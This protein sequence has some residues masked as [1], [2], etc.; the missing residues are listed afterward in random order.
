MLLGFVACQNDY[1]G[2]E[3][4]ANGEAAV[5]LN[6]AIPEDITRAAGANSAL[7][8]VSNID[9]SEY[10]IRFIL[11]V[12]DDANNLAKE[13]IVKYEDNASATSFSLR[14]IPGRGYKFVAWADFVKQ[15]QKGDYHYN[16]TAG[17][18]NI[19]VNEATWKAMD[20]SRD[21]YTTVEE[22]ANFSSAAN[23]SLTLKR[24]F[25]KVRV[26]ATDIKEL[27]GDLLPKDIEVEYLTKFYTSYNALTK[28]ASDAAQT[29][30][31]SVDLSVL[32]YASESPKDNGKMTLFA[33]YMLADVEASPIQFT[34][35][36]VDNSGKTIP[37]INFNT[38]IPIQRNHLTTISGPILTDANDIT[39][40]IDEK[41]DEPAEEVKVWDGESATVPAHNGGDDIN[42][43]TEFY[44]EQGS[45]LAWLAEQVNGVTRATT[46]DFAGV[47]FVL[48]N[49]I[50]LGGNEWTPI[51]VSTGVPFRGSFDG[52][53]YKITNFVVTESNAS[54]Q[55][56]LFGTVCGSGSFKNVLIDNAT[57]KCN[58]TSG[59]TNFYGA[60]LVAQVYG[61]HEFENVTIQN[62]NIQGSGKTGALLGF[63][64]D[65]AQTFKNCKVV[66]CVVESTNP[67]DGG[68][69]G[70]LVGFLQCV[71][72]G[73]TSHDFLFENCS[74]ENVTV[75][76][77]NSRNNGSRANSLFLGGYKSADDWTLTIKGCT[78]VDS[79]LNETYND[80]E[81][82][83]ENPYNSDFVGGERNGEL[84]GVVVINGTRYEAAE[85]PK[86]VS[87]EDGEFYATIK[88][89]LEAGN[90][91]I[92]LGDGEFDM[93]ATLND[94]AVIV[95]NGENTVL[96][97]SAMNGTNYN[98]VTFRNL[99]INENTGNYNGIKHSENLKYE[100]CI[101]NGVFF[102]YATSEFTRCTFNIEG[103]AYNVWTYGATKV[104]FTECTFNSDGKSLL[105]YNEGGNGSDVTFNDCVFNSNGK[106]FEG[107]AAIEIDSSLLKDGMLYNVYINNC[108]VN[109]FADGSVSKNNLY[110]QKK[111]SKSNIYVDGAAVQ[112]AGYAEV[113]G[114]PGLY[115]NDGEYF[116]FDAEGLMSL[117]KYFKANWGANHI[118]QTY[119]IAA[120]ID[121]TGYTWDG[122]FI[123]TGNNAVN[124]LILNGQNH[125]ISNLTINN[126]F[127]SGTPNGGDE[128][129]K[130]G[131]VKNITMD[132]ITVN[133]SSHDATVFWGSC[134]GDVNFENV[135]V[136]NSTI[137]GGSN[138][139]A[140]MS[141]TTI[142]NPNTKVYVGFKNCKVENCK[143]S[144][145]NLNADPTGA[146]GF[147]GR[148]Y[149]NTDVKFEGTNVVDD[150]T[151]I[152]NVD[153]LAGGKVYGYGVWAFGGW[154]GVGA[155][156]TFT[157]WKGLVEV[158]EGVLKSGDD[159]SYY[160]CNKAGLEW[161]ATTVNAG[162]SFSGKSVV[163]CSDIDLNNEEWTP[164]GNSSKAF[165]GKFDGQNHTVSNLYISGDKSDVGLFGFTTDGEIKNLVVENA[166]VTGYL[167]VA[168]VAGT[169][170]T[171]KYT[172]ITVKGHVEVNGF[173][174]VGTVG[175]KN[176]YANWTDVTV[177][178]DRASYVK[179]H[180]VNAEGKAYRTYVGGVCGFNGEGGHIFTNIKSNIDVKGSTIDVGGL[181]G[182][183]HYGNNFKNCS[184]SGDVEVYAAAE[185]ADAEE[186]GGIAGVWHN[187]GSDVT[188]EGCSFTGTLK[189]NISNGVDLSDNTIVGAAYSA[190]GSGKLIIK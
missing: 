127:L 45:E 117:N 116:V 91:E 113:A 87:A 89:A 9:M 189:A 95:G 4:D 55:A 98:N 157:A 107:K 35:D 85:E 110:N 102:L 15:G 6:V 129:M 16:T 24:P 94:G 62:S 120:D 187:G 149:G 28:V 99:T 150:A 182:I 38:A 134:Y 138:V 140:L 1:H 66:N 23:I 106:S 175:G 44:V 155:C 101:L 153:G 3:V 126:Y 26:V 18:T 143:L 17:L 142:E 75:N 84:K 166:N 163:L 34:M 5:T 30:V 82:T 92:V 111:G 29:G 27:Y 36:I 59:E 70:G 11:E 183:A 139:G 22:V 133:G 48:N 178:V 112:L 58:V 146:S 158:A 74:V 141:R 13:R 184:C 83:Y 118:Y 148:A 131:E 7:G 172:N 79:E 185:A 33:D 60:A 21:A 72:G 168:V 154:A 190:T 135:V 136:K 31:K 121:A 80:G 64:G 137:K 76:A 46:N 180:S 186:I 14:L 67:E 147:I 188:F 130:P 90:S 69:I 41:F 78:I 32:T 20:E 152:T 124:G 145:D 161:L 56:A 88:D 125:T 100:D 77:Y 8:G 19:A 57:I 97:M 104:V 119:N 151:V 96:D 10:D 123:V 93:P 179:G 2:L 65:C 171:S 167:D 63:N 103:D 165:S 51:G 176:A 156:D 173:A 43:A 71:G 68:N 49:D 42:A 162:T 61:S 115:T 144:A 159:K 174:Y 50:D 25:A 170:Y 181:F 47:T 105:I 73:S 109:G 108:T 81:V 169:P 114:Y 52:N 39:V 12:Y 177:D 160:I 122:V 40:T 164:I 86:N 37:T 128:G 54:A 132:N 53:G